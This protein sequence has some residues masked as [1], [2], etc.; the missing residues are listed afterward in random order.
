MS[1]S[2]DIVTECSS[3][4]NRPVI[5]EKYRDNIKLIN[6]IINNIDDNKLYL[7]LDIEAFEFNQKFLTEFGWCIFKK[8]GTIVKKKH[9]IVKEN[10]KYRNRKYVPDNRYH[11]L[12]GKSDL[13]Q[14]DDINRELR[15]DIQ[16]VN[17]LV[18]QGIDNDIRYLRTININTSK[19]QKLKDDKVPIYGIIDTMDLYSGFYQTEGVGLEKSLKKLKIPYDRLHNAGND[20]IYTM[21]FFLKII[22]SF[23]NKKNDKSWD[24]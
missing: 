19:F 16:N 12:F 9:A 22:H 23:Q 3:E 18:G 2:S 15:E 4:F 14:L 17:F 11:Y 8:D 24:F 7:C 20:A 6:T 21:K 13:Q 10:L 1:I 5:I